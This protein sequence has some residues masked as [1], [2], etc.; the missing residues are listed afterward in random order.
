M[1]L[2]ADS[3][4]LADGAALTTWTDAGPN[5]RNPTQ[6]TTQN[7][8]LFKTALYNGLPAIRFDGVDDQLK[9]ANY[10]LSSA[11]LHVFIVCKLLAA[12]TNV[13]AFDGLAN[14]QCRFLRASST[15]W[16]MSQGLAVPTLTGQTPEALHVY[17]LEFAGAAAAGRTDGGTAFTANSG[18]ATA[19]GGITLGCKPD[20]TGASNID[21]CEFIA[22]TQILSTADRQ[23]T[24]TYLKGKWGTP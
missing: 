12:T 7:K 21:I 2:K 8:P 11:S 23:A 16:N 15:S 3:L 10:G 18:T 22:C 6:A 17:S 1:W 14:Q 9:T 5:A 20:L 19:A 4:A 24:E 13:T